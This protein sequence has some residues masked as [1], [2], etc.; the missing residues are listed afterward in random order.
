MHFPNDE[1]PITKNTQHV[2]HPACG[3]IS[4]GAS[5]QNLF[6]L[7]LS[8]LSYHQLTF[9]VGLRLRCRDVFQGAAFQL[10]QHVGLRQLGWEARV[11][12]KTQ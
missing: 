4:H 2:L 3:V 11:D 8:N 9:T 12:T 7:K 5:K 10:H 6:V 1:F